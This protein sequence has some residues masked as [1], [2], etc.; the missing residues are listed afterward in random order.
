MIVNLNFDLMNTRKILESCNIYWLCGYHIYVSMYVRMYV[1]ILLL[2]TLYTALC[3]NYS[4]FLFLDI[5]IITNYE[6]NT[7]SLNSTTCDVF[8]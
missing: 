5:F 3:P 8:I 1:P 4:L 2:S 7:F 6:N